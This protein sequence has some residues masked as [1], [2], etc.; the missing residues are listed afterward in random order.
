MEW[1]ARGG[2]WSER[3]KNKVDERGRR[4]GRERGDNFSRQIGP[5]KFQTTIYSIQVNN[6]LRKF[7]I[8][9]MV[10]WYHIDFVVYIN[11]RNNNLSYTFLFSLIIYM[12]KSLIWF[13]ILFFIQ[14]SHLTFK[15]L[16][17]LFIFFFNL[18]I[19]SI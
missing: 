13:F 12:L 5:S 18:I 8:V 3:R 14:F 11:R 2:C 9:K 17:W 15:N 4:W 10:Q 1:K 7:I 19:W 16:F 6:T